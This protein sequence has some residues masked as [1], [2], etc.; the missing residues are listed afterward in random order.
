MRHRMAVTFAA[1]QDGVS[2]DDV[3]ARLTEPLR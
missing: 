1:R 2:L 3:I